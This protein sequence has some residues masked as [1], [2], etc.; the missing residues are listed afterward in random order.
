MS[1]L[2][3]LYQRTVV[4]RV[5]KA[6]KRPVTYI[7]AVGIIF[8]V[9][10]MFFSF[11]ILV[12]EM[13]TSNTKN[14]AAIFSIMVFFLIPAD[15][16]SYSRRRGLIFKLSEVHFIF[17]APEN[18]KRVLIFASIK[19]YLIMAG[20]SLVLAVFGMV[21][22]QIAPW[23][24]LLYFLFLGVFENILE[25]SMIIICYGNQTLPK[26]FFKILPVILF[27]FM[28]IFVIAAI[29]LL[30]TQ[31]MK[32]TTIIDYLTMPAVQAVPVVGWAIAFI[33][34]LLAGPTTVNVICTVCYLVTVVLLFFY[35]RQMKCTG[36]YYED[37]MSFAQEY[38]TRRQKAKKGEVSFGKGKKKYARNVKIEYRGAYAK[39]IFYRQLLEYR[40]NRFF[41]FGWNTLLCLGLG[42]GI[43]LAAQLTDMM[44]EL[45]DMT[46]FVVPAIIAYL[47]FIFSGYATKWSKELENP[48]T[49]LI[50]DSGLKK[51]WY[52]TKMEHI[53]SMIDGCLIT[54][55]A[56][57]FL[58]LDPLIAVLTVLLYV[59]LIANKLY[60]NVLSEAILGNV[61]GNTGKT[62]LRMLFQGIAIV[63]AI[64]LAVICGMIFGVTTGFAAMIIATVVLT[65]AVAVGASTAFDR[66]ESYD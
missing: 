57:L 23:R 43:A 29:V 61:L 58:K 53:R 16:I 8:Y 5:K 54:V 59:C 63:I 46:V 30:Y 50:P 3:Y 1:S 65:I 25:G 22:F 62:L 17:P 12:M 21:F 27:A 52:A 49:Y 10:M 4:N 28:A 36:E 13:D 51:L 31:G 7:A 33:F 2:A 19:N 38:D 64:Y 11:G 34:L 37:A 45:G 15:I 18:P 6:L 32:F 20:L 60:L 42:V 55:P 14:L 47:V 56:A 48:Y 39:A 66:M 35:A 24:M 9:L 40:K 44:Q 26:R 41:I